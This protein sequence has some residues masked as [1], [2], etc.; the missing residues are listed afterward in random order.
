MFIP[1]VPKDFQV[2]VKLQTQDFII[3]KLCFNDAELDYKAVMSS[4]NVIKQTRGGNWPT[5][6]LS[7]LDDQ[8]DLAWHQ[9]E[10][11]NKSSFAYT[12]ISPDESECLGCLYLYQP[13]F[14]SEFSREAD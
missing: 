6:D 4:I 7:F 5:S 3:R 1:L 9:R 10:F 14:R 2:P 13:G 12:V 11:E 8:I